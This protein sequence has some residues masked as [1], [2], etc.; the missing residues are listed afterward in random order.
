MNMLKK[1]KNDIAY[2]AEQETFNLRM[3]DSYK[4]YSDDY[5][6]YQELFGIYFR[7][8]LAVTREA[9]QQHP[10]FNVEKFMMSLPDWC[11]GESTEDEK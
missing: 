4:L 5:N 10:S 8:R 7:A 1:Y 2:L 6:Y 11:T 3:R 9:K